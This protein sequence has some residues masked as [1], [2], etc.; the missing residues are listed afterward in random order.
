MKNF[1]ENIEKIK[2]SDFK[3]IFNKK[4]NLKER[5]FLNF[6]LN[7][8]LKQKKIIL[9]IEKNFFINELKEKNIDRFLKLFFEKKILIMNSNNELS[10]ILNL[11]SCFLIN[12]NKFIFF[13]SETIYDYLANNNNNILLRY[14]LEI[15]LKFDN[16]NIKNLFF[17]LLIKFK[18]TYEILLTKKEIKD[19]LSLEEEY[20]RFFDLESKFI[21]PTLS[22]I[23]ELCNFDIKY[24]KIKGTQAPNSKISHLKF[25]FPND[26]LLENN[27][28]I[29]SLLKNYNLKDDTKLFALQM[30]VKKS[31]EYVIKNV[32]YFM[33][34]AENNF[35]TFL[36][37]CLRYDFVNTH[38]NNL[39]NSKLRDSKIIIN[40]ITIFN[41]FKE[42]EKKL[43]E[44]ISENSSVEI[45]E[46]I[47]LH[48]TLKEIVTDNYNKMAKNKKNNFL[49]DYNE[50]LLQL[51]HMHNNKF[52]YYEDSTFIFL[53]EFNNFKESSIYILK[54]ENLI[55]NYLSKK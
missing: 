30:I 22:L 28:R 15:L 43:K 25:T 21:L 44:L 55:N 42:F 11:I 17:Y 32:Y 14:Q 35:D 24:S 18:N 50:L 53:A 54:K 12:E 23:K 38:F 26:N 52:F 37:K 16:P 5:Y 48:T 10:G 4:I 46:I 7:T 8:A 9:E 39:L 41:S 1:F 47:L 34:H 33:D 31:F 36:I 3:L 6:L 51:E 13:I 20:S 45:K 19:I 40:L 2:N 27:K 29:L 49:Y